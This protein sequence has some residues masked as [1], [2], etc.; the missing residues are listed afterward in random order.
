MNLLRV[1]ILACL[2]GGAIAFYACNQK[3]LNH[4]YLTGVEH[5]VHDPMKVC[6]FVKDKC[7]TI[8]DEIKLT[9][10]WLLRSEPLVSA[11]ASLVGLYL[12]KAVEA[13]TDVMAFDPQ[14]IILKYTVRRLVPYQY[15]ICQTL[16]SPVNREEREFF[17]EQHDAHMMPI[18]RGMH[19]VTARGQPFNLRNFTHD[20]YRERR[21]GGD[22]SASFQSFIPTDP[23]YDQVPDFRTGELTRPRVRCYSHRTSYLKEFVVVN[24]EKAKFCLALYENFLNFDMKKFI[25]LLPLVR[26][27]LNGIGE[28]KKSLYCFLCDAHSQNKF[29]VAERKIVFS[30]QFCR[31]LLITYKDY[32]NFMHVIFIEYADSLLQYIACFE[33]NARLLPLPYPNFLVK[34]RRRISLVKRCLARINEQDYLLHCWF[35]CNKFSLHQMS[36]FWDGD[37]VLLMRLYTTLGSFMR[38]L[39]VERQEDE[40]FEQFKRRRGGRPV[41]T[42]TGNVDGLIIEPLL[43]P[44]NPASLVT[45]RRFYMEAAD[46]VQILNTTDTRTYV[47]PEVSGVLSQFMRNI[48]MR[49]SGDLVRAQTDNEI[50]QERLRNLTS[51]LNGTGNLTNGSV[52]QVNGLL[53]KLSGILRHNQ[54]NSGFYPRHLAP[55]NAAELARVLREIRPIAYN[56]SDF[57]NGNYSQK[58]LPAIP[59]PRIKYQVRNPRPVE[60]IS[61]IF[62]KSQTEM[63]IHFFATTLDAD[64]LNPIYGTAHSHFTYNMT[65]ILQ[66]TFVR[67][68]S[69]N[70]DVINAFLDNS[71]KAINAFNTDIDLYFVPMAELPDLRRIKRILRYAR[72]K[73]HKALLNEALKLEKTVLKEYSNRKNALD[74][75]RVFEKMRKQLMRVKA[76]YE[77]I[78]MLEAKNRTDHS[79]FPNFDENFNGFAAFFTSIFGK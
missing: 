12:R 24:E 73:N 61:Q 36:S 78:K 21:W 77:Q 76:E 29:N 74:K 70:L 43:E 79:H 15:K 48:G 1:T 10:Y 9:N 71:N 64:G 67:E 44:L 53:N 16:Q 72:R 6:T 40:K 20:R 45:D 18:Y 35:L 8:A 2:G 28:M 60:D 32:V 3:L 39:G 30:H 49:D 34:Y 22:Y 57:V 59:K 27:N 31:S 13:F 23:V 38:K 25:D 63:N 68:E 47:P 62:E 51:A 7:C 4:F 65:A 26:S 66:E 41:F 69:L 5:S 52:S 55:S 56:V 11:R 19:N 50:L 17:A 46:M 42:T 33:T 58:T 37:L 54:L 14:D 75:K